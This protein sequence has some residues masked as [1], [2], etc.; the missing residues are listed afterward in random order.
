MKTQAETI[1]AIIQGA[2]KVNPEAFLNVRASDLL[3]A[4]QPEPPVDEPS[5]D[6]PAD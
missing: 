3:L 1:A 5:N 6:Q 2:S 4:L